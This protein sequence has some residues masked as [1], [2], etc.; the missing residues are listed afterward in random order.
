MVSHAFNIPLTHLRCVDI[1]NAPSFQ[2]LEPRIPLERKLNLLRIE[3][4]EKKD[5]MSCR[6]QHPK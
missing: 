4:L 5:L 3:H 1:N 2:H 6:A